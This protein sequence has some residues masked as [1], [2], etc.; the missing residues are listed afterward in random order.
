MIIHLSTRIHSCPAIPI[1]GVH[2][3]TI[4]NLSPLTLRTTAIDHL[5]YLVTVVLPMCRLKCGSTTKAKEATRPAVPPSKIED[6]NS[7][8][9]LP[10]VRKRGPETRIAIAELS[11][12]KSTAERTTSSEWTCHRRH[13]RLY[14]KH[15]ISKT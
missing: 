2:C 10:Y 9:L 15:N 12:T 14:K 6:A 13:F 7:P 4:P 1:T 5:P 8:F 11:T 3:R